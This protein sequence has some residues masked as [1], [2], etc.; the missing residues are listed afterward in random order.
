MGCGTGRLLLEYRANGLDVDGMDVCPEMLAICKEKASEQ[1]LQVTLYNQTMESMAIPRHYQTIIV[2]S[3]TFQLM[4]D[5]GQAESALNRFFNHLL[6]GVTLVLSNWHCK[7]KGLA[8]WGDWWLVSEKDGL[9]DAKSIKHW[10][11]SIYDPNTQ[12]RHAESCYELFENGEVVYTEL[13]RR[14]PELRNYSLSQ[15]TSMLENA[16]YV[17]VRAVSE[18]TSDPAT[19]E[20]GTFYIIGGRE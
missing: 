17:Q 8:E 2:P 13:H 3:Y 14:S 5:F 1:S 20:D 15:L 18:N 9:E 11:R 7:R 6:S 4:P 19:E 10:E 12:L 16:G